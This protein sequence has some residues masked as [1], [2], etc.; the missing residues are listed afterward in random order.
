MMAG[1]FTVN[2]VVEEDKTQVF[3]ETCVHCGESSE[4]GEMISEKF[5]C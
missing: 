1:E 5:F 2:F 3:A 4:Y